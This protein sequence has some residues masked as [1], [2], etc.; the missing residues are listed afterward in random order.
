MSGQHPS[1]SKLLSYLLAD[2]SSVEMS[3]VVRH[4]AGGCEQC[5]SN[6]ELHPNGNRPT[7]ETR[8]G[9]WHS[10]AEQFGGAFEEVFDQVL[11]R[12]RSSGCGAL[13]VMPADRQRLTALH[14]LPFGRQRLLVQNSTSYHAPG[15]VLA[16]LAESWSIRFEAPARMLELAELA[17]VC[18]LSCGGSQQGG[19]S[20]HG[21]S[22]SLDQSLVSDLRARSFALKANALRI[23]GDIRAAREALDEAERWLLQGSGGPREVAE[24]LEVRAILSAYGSANPEAIAALRMAIA[25]YRACGEGH[26]MGRALLNLGY[27][28]SRQGDFNAEVELVQEALSHLDAQLEP[29]L[30]LAGW[31][32]LLHSLHSMGRNREA[33]KLLAQARPLYLEVGDRMSL[34]RFQWLEGLIAESLERFEQAEGCYQEVRKRFVEA[35]VPIDAA[36]A[37]LDLAALLLKQERHAE[38]MRLSSEMLSV[39]RAHQVEEEALAALILLSQAAKRREL[40]VAVLNEVG[41]R[42]DRVQASS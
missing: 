40:T 22:E 23:G 15:T 36:L 32:N 2:L 14:D 42:L 17:V 26:L 13:E 16:L 41:E 30:V 24:H 6:I 10:A 21:G 7:P 29:T 31:H 11:D 3:Q 37:S 39:F 27:L 20:L 1:R 25:L 34:V 33:L 35:S 12:V 18:S 8:P 9:S 19:G 4:L 38:V 5:A 28:L